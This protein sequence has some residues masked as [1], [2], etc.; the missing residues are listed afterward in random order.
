MEVWRATLNKA[1]LLKIGAL[2]NSAAMGDG[3]VLVKSF[4]PGDDPDE[5]VSEPF[6][7]RKGIVKFKG[8]STESVERRYMT[9]HDPME[10][11][12]R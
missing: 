6:P 7:L 5:Q 4:I 12:A 1:G 8:R 11:C 3:L 9:E 10:R 2:Q